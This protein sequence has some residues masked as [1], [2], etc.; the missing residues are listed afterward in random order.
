LSGIT[1][2]PPENSTEDI[3]LD[4]RVVVT[5]ND[6]ASQSFDKD[7]IIH[8]EPVVDATNYTNHST[9]YEDELTPIDWRPNLTDSKEQV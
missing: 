5:E 6:G 9:G 2:I 4:V 3:H 1:I 8:I 7:V